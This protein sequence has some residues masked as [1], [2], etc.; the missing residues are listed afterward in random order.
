[1]IDR[2]R[3]RSI[4]A[5]RVAPAQ[6]GA[7]GLRSVEVQ[8][9]PIPK[10]R[11]C[12]PPRSAQQVDPHRRD[13]VRTL[14]P[15]IVR[16]LIQCGQPGIRAVPETQRQR[17]VGPHHRRVGHLQQPVWRFVEHADVPAGPW[18]RIITTNPV[19]PL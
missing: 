8:R 10:Q 6:E 14:Q 2:P 3:C 7:A 19:V 1:M 17:A 12:R 18:T 11:F 4:A 16:H 13:Q 9:F 5:F 15:R